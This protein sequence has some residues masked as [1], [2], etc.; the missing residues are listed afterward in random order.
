MAESIA[1]TGNICESAQHQGMVGV[2]AELP[3]WADQTVV[4]DKEPPRD[5]KSDQ[6]RI[7]ILLPDVPSQEQDMYPEPAKENITDPYITRS[8]RK[9]VAPNRLDL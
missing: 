4:Q 5:A 6:A 2:N 1:A 8:D 3:S 7:P 9:V